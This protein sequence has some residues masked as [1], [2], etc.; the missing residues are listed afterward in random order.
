M[1]RTILDPTSTIV[2]CPSSRTMPVTISPCS[3]ALFWGI[4][5]GLLPGQH[6]LDLAVAKRIDDFVRNSSRQRASVSGIGQCFERLH[7][8]ANG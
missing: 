6:G 1:G 4:F 8:D 7:R 3:T 5:A 2:L